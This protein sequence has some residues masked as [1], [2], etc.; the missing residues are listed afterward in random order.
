MSDA[1]TLPEIDHPSGAAGPACEKCGFATKAAACPKCGWYPSLGIHVDIDEAFEAVMN[2]PAASDSP[3]GDD[4][5]DRPDWR[6][7]LAVWRDLIP[8]WAWMMIGTTLGIVAAAV[9]AR[10]ATLSAPSAQTTIGVSGLAGG[11][12][13]SLVLH[14]V[15]FVLGSSESAD[16]G[17]ADILIKPLKVWKRY[18]AGLPERLWLVNGANAALTTAASAA[19]IVGGVPYEKL[20]DWGFVQP[21]KKDLVNLVAQ[22]AGADGSPDELADAVNEFGSSV[23]VEDEKKADQAA[24]P[25]RK[26]ETVVIGFRTD[27]DEQLS[28]LLLAADRYG[29]LAYVGAVRPELERRERTELLWKMQESTAPRPLVKTSQSATW[30]RPRFMCRV[31]YTEWPRGRRPQD[32]EWD[33]LLDEVKLP[34]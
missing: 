10:V 15:A 21:P 2:A 3:E 32:L 14:V 1:T 29:E 12:F 4:P 25:R 18:L 11:L 7:H 28:E 19:L 34:W 8:G 24:K 33:T 30:L 23:G 9:V 5:S 31:T 26:L 22:K 20:L 16:F 13:T 6:K 17:V 27:S